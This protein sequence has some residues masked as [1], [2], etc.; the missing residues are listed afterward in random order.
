MTTQAYQ[1]S[2]PA[3]QPVS[4]PRF[5]PPD[6]Q[7]AVQMTAYARSRPLVRLTL[8][9]EAVVPSGLFGGGVFVLAVSAIKAGIS[10]AYVVTNTPLQLHYAEWW[11]G[12]SLSALG[13]LI[14]YQIR[15]NQYDRE[16]IETES[17]QGQPAPQGQPQR[18]KDTYIIRP[19]EGAMT[20]IPDEPKAG[21]LRAFAVAIGRGEASFS[22]EGNKDQRGAR[23]YGYSRASFDALRIHFAEMGWG[24]WRNEG[25]QN[26]YVELLAAG[27]ATLKRIA[28]TGQHPPTPRVATRPQSDVGDG[29]TDE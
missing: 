28:D 14:H 23:D 10:A 27:K 12:L 25:K 26:K 13:W 1:Y 29:R 15:L 3:G 21:A 5:L 16:K 20:R 17:Y 19:D 8:W 2:I 7:P 22:H 11:G 6:E 4:R 24:I 18:G 9:S